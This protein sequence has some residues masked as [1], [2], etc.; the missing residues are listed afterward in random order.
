MKA[1][2]TEET[3]TTIIT[4]YE[5]IDGTIF[6]SKDECKKYEDTAICVLRSRYNPLVIT[7]TTEY[8]LFQVGS[9]ECVIDVIKLQSEQDVDTILQLCHYYHNWLKEDK[10]KDRLQK[11]SIRINKAFS[12]NDYLFI[13]KGWESDNF[14]PLFTYM[15]FA[16]HIISK[17]NSNDK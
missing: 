10:C 1:I 16:D 14:M 11:I 17:L 4:K 7:S 12:E 5:A 9:D 2:Q 15:Q 8:D 13:S 3:I 6:E